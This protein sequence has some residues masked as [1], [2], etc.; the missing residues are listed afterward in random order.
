MNHKGLFGEDLFEKK[1][2]IFELYEKD[3]RF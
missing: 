2:M 3:T 1:A